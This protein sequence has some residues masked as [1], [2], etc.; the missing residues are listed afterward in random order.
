VSYSLHKTLIQGY[1]T[2]E[3]CVLLNIGGTGGELDI[4]LVNSD[5]EL[6]NFITQRRERDIW[7]NFTIEIFTNGD[8]ALPK[9]NAHDKETVR[10]GDGRLER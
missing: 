3:S 4:S 10:G 8:D 1:Q 7:H 6:N 5:P 2:K 9:S